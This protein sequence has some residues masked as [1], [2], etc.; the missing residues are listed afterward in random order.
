MIQYIIRRLPFLMFK[1]KI[2]KKPPELNEVYLF[3]IAVCCV[4]RCLTFVLRSLN[5]EL[6]AQYLNI[7]FWFFL[8]SVFLF[9]IKNTQGFHFFN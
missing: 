4:S 5:F 8:I 2:K 7:F 3:F 6:V 9:N 1:K